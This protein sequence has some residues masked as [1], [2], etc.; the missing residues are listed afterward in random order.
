MQGKVAWFNSK[1]GYGFITGEDKKD[2]FVHYKNIQGEG[3][4][5]LE[6]DELVTFKDDYNGEK[7]AIALE[8]NRYE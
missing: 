1:K 7:G 2:Y 4:K 8:V 5:T 3:Y 6:K